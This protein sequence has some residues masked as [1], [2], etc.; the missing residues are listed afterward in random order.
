[1][2]TSEIV[3]WII[4]VIFLIGPLTRKVDPSLYG[5]A[6]QRERR[7]NRVANA[8]NWALAFGLLA[9]KYLFGC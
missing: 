3:F 7:K 8:A 4:V 2:E 6:Q 5:S 9:G 1:M